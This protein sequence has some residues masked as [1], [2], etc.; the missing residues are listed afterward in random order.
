MESSGGLSEAY[1]SRPLSSSLSRFYD[2]IIFSPEGKLLL[3]TSNLTARFWTGSLWLF[4][5]AE[6]VSPEMALCNMCLPSAS[7]CMSVIPEKSQVIVGLDDGSV[8]VIKINKTDGWNFSCFASAIEHDA[9]ISA[10]DITS[11]NEKIVSSADDGMIKV[12]DT[13]SLISTTTFRNTHSDSISDICCSPEDPNVFVSCSVNGEITWWDLRLPKPAKDIPYENECSSSS[14]LTFTNS[15]NIAFGTE[16]GH[17]LVKDI[18]NLDAPSNI[19]RSHNR[20]I[21]RIKSFQNY[22]AVGA[23]DSKLVILEAGS[24]GDYTI[25]YQDNKHTDFIRG[26]SWNPVTRSVYSSG[27]DGRI[28][29]HSI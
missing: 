25:R 6:S 2:D 3:L 8:S 11:Q 23:D 9:G 27:W 1:E 24:S 7:G 20:R 22:L 26:L 16:S 29:R 17:V 13:N 5:N 10:L 15:G 19:L 12:W 18:K 4:E 21:H 28:L 14:C